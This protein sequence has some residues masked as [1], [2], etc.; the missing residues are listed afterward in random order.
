MKSVKLYERLKKEKTELS[1]KVEQLRALG[2][3]SAERKEGSPD[4]KS[5]V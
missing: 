5:V 2:Q 4:R 1:E 3:P